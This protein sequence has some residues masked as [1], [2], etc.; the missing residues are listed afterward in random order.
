[1]PAEAKGTSARSAEAFVRHYIEAVNYGLKTGDVSAIRK[2][3]EP[4]CSS[5]SAVAASIDD[6]YKRGDRLVG[7]GWDVKGVAP[8]AN[9]PR[10]RPVLQVSVFINPQT[11]VSG[12]GKQRENRSGGRKLMVFDLASTNGNW[13]VSQWEQS[14]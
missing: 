11:K 7:K 9:Q 1:M 2:L 8:V 13:L 4:D 3:S 6:V 5:C 14:A 12:S 10:L